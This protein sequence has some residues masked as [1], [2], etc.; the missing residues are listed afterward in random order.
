MNGCPGFLRGINPDHA[1]SNFCFWQGHNT[2]RFLY[3]F[4]G[5]IDGIH[6]DIVHERL[7][8]ILAWHQSTID[9]VLAF[10][11]GLDQKIIHLPGVADFPA[12]GLLVKFLGAFDVVCWYL[13][14]NDCVWHSKLLFSGSIISE[15]RR[16]R[17]PGGLLAAWA[18]CCPWLA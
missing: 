3:L 2:A 6:R 8:W 7:P 17:A 9:A 14:M 11:L 4:D 1:L 5:G 15:S 18:P 13:K 16:K 10:F 12:K